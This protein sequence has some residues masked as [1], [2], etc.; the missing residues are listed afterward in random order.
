MANV[1]LPLSKPFKGAILVSNLPG[2]RR[3]S[4]D[5][6]GPK[7]RSSMLQEEGYAVETTTIRDFPPRSGP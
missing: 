3:M 5:T 2:I 6:T 1:G 7:C 4:V